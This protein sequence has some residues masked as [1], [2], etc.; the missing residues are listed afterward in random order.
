MGRE[1]GK[2]PANAQRRRPRSATS[3]ASRQACMCCTHVSAPPA[4]WARAPDLLEQLAPLLGR[5]GKGD[6]PIPQVVEDCAGQPAAGGATVGG[7]SRILHG[8]P[9]VSG[10]VHQMLR[11]R[12][13]QHARGTTMAAASHCIHSSLSGCT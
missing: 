7:A 10:H 6:P 11:A 5:L 4:R 3:S 2:P 13:R 1:A 12:L 9:C 8:F